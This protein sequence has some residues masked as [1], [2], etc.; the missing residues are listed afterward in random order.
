[1][2]VDSFTMQMITKPEQ[3]DVVVIENMFGDI[4]TDLGAVLQGGIESGVSGNINPTGEYPSMFEPIHGTAPDKWYKRNQIGGYIPGTKVASGYRTIR[5]EA[6]F[7]AYA[8]MLEQMGELKASNL[9]KEAAHENLR[10]PDYKK[11]HHV[12]LVNNA[13]KYITDTIKAK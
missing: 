8:M 13:V 10:N 11:M 3:F 6:A 12:D 1:M 9:L 2:H 4:T 5:S 7:L